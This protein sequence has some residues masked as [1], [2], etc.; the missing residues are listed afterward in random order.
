[1]GANTFE[2]Y[3]WGK[4]PQEAFQSAVEDAQHECGHGGYTGT[5]AEKHDFTMIEVPAK[6][7]GNEEEY[8][9]HL[10]QEDDSRISDKWGPA[11]C[12]IVQSKDSFDEVPYAT[13]VERYKQQG[14][15]KWE[16]AYRLTAP[17]NYIRY[18][19]SQT[20]AEK[21]A[22]EYAKAHN[23]SVQITIL[24]RLMNGDDRIVRVVPKT[25]TVKSKQ[26]LN[27]YLFFG[28]ASS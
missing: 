26:T 6:W 23:V 5:I 24:K 15:R 22:K 18:E 12:I 11:G 9:Y 16:T 4:T 14:A 19:N 21:V 20:E 3:A 1:M 25:K 7:K 10:M 27:K 28:W 2:D 8:A 17:E 13:I